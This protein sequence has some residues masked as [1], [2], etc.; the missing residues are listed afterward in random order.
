MNIEPRRESLPEYKSF[1][2]STDRNCI[3]YEPAWQIFLISVFVFIWPL[4]Y[5]WRQIVP[6]KGQYIAIGNDFKKWYYVYKIYLL[7]HLSQFHIPL[8]S[9]AEAAGFPF[10]SSPLTQTFYPLN[11]FL[12]I[13]YNLAGGYT[14][15]DHQVFTILGVSIFSLGLFFWL[16]Q[17]NLN[18]RAVL[19]ATLVMSVSFKMAEILRFPNAV[20]TAAWYPWILFAITSILQKQSVKEL[21][22]S[23]FLLFFFLTC[24]FT[25]GYPY[26]IYYSLFLFFPYLLLFLIPKLRHKFFGRQTIRLTNSLLTLL[27]SSIFSILI[28]MP[29]LYKINLLLKETVGRGGGDFQFATDISSNYVD[30]IGSLIFPPIANPGG[31]FYFGILGVFLISLYFFL[32]LSGVYF[33][34]TNPSELEK[35]ENRFGYPDPWIIVLFLVWMGTIIYIT[36]GK[37]SALFIFLWKYMPFFSPL[38]YW[39]RMN[40]ILVPILGWLLAIAYNYFE[41]LISQSKN[42]KNKRLAAYVLLGVY[43]AILI[44]QYDVFRNK[45]YDKY[46]LLLFQHAASKEVLFIIF[47]GLAFVITWFFLNLPSKINVQSPQF[48]GIVLSCFILF[49]TLDMRSVGANMWI[50]PSSLAT[51]TRYKLNVAKLNME[52]FTVPRIEAGTLSISSAFS[53]GNKDTKSFNWYFNRYVEFIENKEEQLT[54]RRKLLG[55]VDGRKLYFSKA[56]DYPTIKAFLEDATQ[57]KNFE[58][59]I[60]YTG[61]EL[62]LNVN[63]T[64]EGYLSFI[65]NWDSDWEATLDSKPT[66]IELLFETFKSVQIPPGEHR[67]I[68]AYRP[69]LFKMFAEK[70][71]S[72]T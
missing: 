7:D 33:S 10:Y 37:N 34:Y 71:K 18:I 72:S 50:Y 62:V 70:R 32:G 36:Y 27:V 13:F 3:S 23:G 56:I 25:G 43:V 11:L 54:Y 9:P 4:V 8:W 67:L 69:N 26:Y 24:F 5:F 57:F 55:I 49:S 15:L 66:K 59:V 44:I 2:S 16:R 52:S 61:D 68:F 45:L 21:A 51:T 22:V 6:F 38:R 46:W 30:T 41:V 65:D 14:R 17:L 58:R 20:H 40:I 28:C 47:G 60:S 64:T 19:F 39:T 53:V 12:V 42:V 31:W 63:V 35:Q 48:L 29:Y 1:P